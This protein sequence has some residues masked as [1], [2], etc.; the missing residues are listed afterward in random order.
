MFEPKLKH[1]LDPAVGADI[2]ERDNYSSA[3]NHLP[4]VREKFKQDEARGW[5]V[6]MTDEEAKLKYGDKLHIASLG[7]VEE[8]NKI[9]VIHSE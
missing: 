9:R 7:V 5:M 6:R 2:L 4:A 1:R 3:E 8:T